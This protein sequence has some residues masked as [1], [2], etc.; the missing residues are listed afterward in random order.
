MLMECNI[1]GSNPKV[2]VIIPC[3]N[4]GKYLGQAIE[5]VLG[6]SFPDFELIV[7]D[8]GSTDNTREIV[9]SFNDKRIVYFHQNNKGFPTAHNVALNM[10]RGKYFCILDADDWWLSSKM[11]EYNYKIMESDTTLVMSYARA[12]IYPFESSHEKVGRKLPSGFIFKHLLFRDFIPMGT[13]MVPTKLAKLVGFDESI[14]YMQ[15][16]P[17]KLKIAAL[18]KVVFWDENVLA[19]R[20]HTQSV[21]N[22]SIRLRK[23]A[24]EVISKLRV[25]PYIN[26]VS[27]Q[28]WQQILSI[29]HFDCG[30]E[31]E[32]ANELAIARK[33]YKASLEHWMYNWK[34]AVLLIGTKS[35]GLLKNIIFVKNFLTRGIG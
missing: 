20:K 26:L 21:S 8:D 33:H 1:N 28:Y 12:C 30:K 24:I 3:Y 17:F 18:G 15:D 9:F 7:C 14:P 34:A 11:I 31:Y 29:K 23:N 5:S 6:Q 35:G 25:D 19:Y 13:F 16:Y 10:A 27:N 32:L 2:S 4:Y 22:S